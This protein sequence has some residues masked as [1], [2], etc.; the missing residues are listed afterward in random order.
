MLYQQKHTRISYDLLPSC[1]LCTFISQLL[2][3][4]CVWQCGQVILIFPLPR[5]TRRRRLQ[6]G[7]LKYRCVLRSAN[8]MRAL[9]RRVENRAPP[10]QELLILCVTGLNIARKHT[11]VAQDEQRQNKHP[12]PAPAGNHLD[13]DQ[14]QAEYEQR[15]VKLVISGTPRHELT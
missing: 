12:H 14:N 7:H 1:V 4:N 11:K 2:R 9:C 10:A 6:L 8:R 3:T 13:H 15:C 5:G